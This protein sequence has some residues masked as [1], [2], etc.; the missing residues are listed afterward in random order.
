[1]DGSETSTVLRACIAAP[2]PVAAATTAAPRGSGD[3]PALLTQ[4]E[5]AAELLAEDV[6]DSGAES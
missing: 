6:A 3:A 1:M 2:A 5:A 4:R